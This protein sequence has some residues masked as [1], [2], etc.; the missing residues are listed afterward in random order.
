[1]DHNNI[2]SPYSINSDI[3]EVTQVTNLVNNALPVTSCNLQL[4]NRL[5]INKKL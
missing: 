4:F 1:M 5:I 3:L 2:F